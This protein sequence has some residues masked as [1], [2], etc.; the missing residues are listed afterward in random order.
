[1]R[2]GG[3]W[4]G[5]RTFILRF[6]GERLTVVVLCNYAQV[7]PVLLAEEVRCIW[8]PPASQEK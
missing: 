7:N 1:M 5:F 6:L 8:G 4:V 2:H 3:S